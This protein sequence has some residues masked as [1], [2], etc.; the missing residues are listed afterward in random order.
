[1]KKNKKWMFTAGIHVCVIISEH[2][3]SYS[4]TKTDTDSRGL[5]FEM[6]N[7]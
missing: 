4:H 7:A 2:H 5:I 6:L 1:M 3:H